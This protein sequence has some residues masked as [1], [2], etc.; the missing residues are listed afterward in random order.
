VVAL[1]LALFLPNSPEK[2]SPWLLPKL[3]I[4]SERERYI[5]KTRV[6]L[7]DSQKAQPKVHI[8]FAEFKKAV[9]PRHASDE[10]LIRSAL[11]VEQEPLVRRS[12]YPDHCTNVCPVRIFSS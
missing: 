1:V 3:D 2:T 4:F 7:D 5:M 12:Q 6:L 10:K 8:S 11:D 9:S